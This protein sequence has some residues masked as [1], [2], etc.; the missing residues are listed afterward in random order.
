MRRVVYSDMNIVIP[1]FA[2]TYPVFFM[3]L[4]AVLL[5]LMF[6]S[7]MVITTSGRG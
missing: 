5:I 6:Q 1:I 4:F 3:T 2:Y 7:D